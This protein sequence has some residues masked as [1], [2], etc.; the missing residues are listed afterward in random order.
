VGLLRLS[1]SSSDNADVATGLVMN[2]LYD[3]ECEK[4]TH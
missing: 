3:Y 2:L 1:E 4:G